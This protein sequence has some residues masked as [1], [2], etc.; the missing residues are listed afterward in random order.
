MAVPSD[1]PRPDL[2]RLLDD[3]ESLARIV[4]PDTPGWTRRFPSPAYLAG[5][6]WVRERMRQAG[7]ETRIDAGANL[8]GYLAGSAELP[9]IMLGSHSDTVYGGGRYDGPLGVLGGLEVVRCLQ[10]AGVRL[11]HPLIVADYL[12]EEVNPF[13][14]SC[15][16]SRALAGNFRPE[17]R[18]RSA[19]GQTLGEAISAAGGQPDLLGAPLV[20]RGAILACLELHIEQGPV[21]EQRKIGLAAVSGIVGIRRATFELVGRP[22]HA[23]TTP[24]ALRH[25]ALAAAAVMVTTLEALCRA[26]PQAVGTIGR[27]EVTPNQGNVVPSQVVLAAEVRSL[28]S[29]IIERIWNELLAASEAACQERGV[30]LR[31]VTRTDAVPARPAD[32]L[33]ELVLAACR[34]LE[35]A[36]LLLPSGAGHDTAHLG[37]I[38]P[39][40]MIF[41]PSIGG[42]S[43]CPEELTTPEQLALGVQALV[44]AVLKLDER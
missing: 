44:A 14:V 36:T 1:L 23:G 17:W 21:L 12:A 16:G 18:E 11:R 8:L 13:G 10:D 34:S 26:E 43:H 19:L 5:R 3:L 39:A 6:D 35:P 31:L 41:V 4:E 20:R 9:P 37:Q 22:D 42:R 25:D 30:E 40:A 33:L 7:L 2:E 27:L 28:D 29:A 38:A 32:W 24:M 15:V